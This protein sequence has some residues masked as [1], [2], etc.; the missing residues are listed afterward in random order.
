MFD[1]NSRLVKQ[2]ILLI[3]EDIST[4]NDVPDLFNLREVVRYVLDKRDSSIIKNDNNA[5]EGGV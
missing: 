1:E 4:F 2:Q 5:M 3:D